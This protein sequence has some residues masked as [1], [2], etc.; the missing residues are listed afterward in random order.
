MDAWGLGLFDEDRMHYHRVNVATL[1]E[2][3]IH[4]E[5]RLNR[6]LFNYLLDILG[7]ELERET[8]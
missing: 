5:T 2:H 7:P 8:R 1:P 3:I 4:K 6:Q